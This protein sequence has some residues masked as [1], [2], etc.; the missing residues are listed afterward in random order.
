MKAF[1]PFT[2][3]K[4]SKNWVMVYLIMTIIYPLMVNWYLLSFGD[5]RNG[6]IKDSQNP[7]VEDYLDGVNFNYDELGI[8][9]FLYTVNHEVYVGETGLYNFGE[10]N[11]Q[12]ELLVDLNDPENYLVPTFSSIYFSLSGLNTFISLFFMGIFI[13]VMKDE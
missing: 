1:E 13:Y 7:F 11:E 3:H 2:R 4:V 10:L 5:K 9:T 8:N 6:I 12:I